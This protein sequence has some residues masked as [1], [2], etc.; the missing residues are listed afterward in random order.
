LAFGP[1]LLAFIAAAQRNLDK[2]Q[3]VKKKQ[4]CGAV[5]YLLAAAQRS[6]LWENKKIT[7]LQKP[8]C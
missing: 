3:R 8:R 5:L 1:W 4:S 2:K 6:I 7:D